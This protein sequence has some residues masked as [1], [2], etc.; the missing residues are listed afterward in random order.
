[1]TKI[2]I[3]SCFSPKV[4][5]FTHRGENFQPRATSLKYANAQ[6]IRRSRPCADES[7][8]MMFVVVSV[9]EVPRSARIFLWINRTA[10]HVPKS[11]TGVRYEQSNWGP[12]GTS[13]VESR[14]SGA[15]QYRTHA[16]KRRRARLRRVNNTT[17]HRSYT[18]K[19]AH[20]RK[21]DLHRCDRR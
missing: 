15:A 20:D 5:V 11:R 19:H 12:P 7:Y 2:A 4:S 14:S 8:L 13:G 18:R 1:M 3:S 16:R 17:E 10:R 21:N 6:I 9:R